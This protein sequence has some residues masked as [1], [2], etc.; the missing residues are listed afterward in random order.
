MEV[1][2]QNA[3]TKSFIFPL[4]LFITKTQAKAYTTLKASRFSGVSVK[5]V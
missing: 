3:K 4:Y 1:Q 5:S 2:T